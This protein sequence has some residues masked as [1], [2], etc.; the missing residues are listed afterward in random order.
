MPKLHTTVQ[1]DKANRL[2]VARILSSP[3][4]TVSLEFLREALRGLDDPHT[5]DIIYDLRRHEAMVALDEHKRHA[6]FFADFMQGT[7][8]GRGMLI[9][10]TEHAVRL[11]G[12]FYRE[13]YHTRAVHV[14]DSLDEAIECSRG[15]QSEA[16]SAA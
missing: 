11:R 8:Q 4:A 10:T 15:L 7:D 16:N 5:Y 6:A 1:I 2:I 13:F 3:D 9:V 12:E 14:C